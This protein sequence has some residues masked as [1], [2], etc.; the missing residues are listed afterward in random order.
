MHPVTAALWTAVMLAG[1]RLVAA[2]PDSTVDYSSKNLSSV[3]RD[4]PKGVEF[5]DLSCN[6]IQQL[7]RDDFRNMS[8]LRSLNVSWNSLETIDPDTFLD[9]PLLEDLDLSHN[10]LRNLSGQQYLLN[11]GNLQQLNL[12]SNAFS[13]MTLG[14]AFSSLV[15][16][17][18]LALEAKNISV[19]DFKN[20]AEVK[21]CTLTLCLGDELGYEARSLK[22]VNAQRLQMISSS[23][24]MDCG[25]Y[26]DALSLFA[27]VE[28]MNLTGGY[29]ELSKILSEKVKILTSHLYFT[30]ISIEWKDLTHYVNVILGSSIAHLGISG[31]VMSHL[32]YIDSYVIQES[33]MKSFSARQAMVKSFFFSQEAVCNFFINMPVESL[34][35]TTTSIIHMTCPKSPSPVLKLDF[36]NCALSD[37][38]F[39]RVK[40]QQTLECQN[41]GNVTQLILAGNNLKSLQLISVRTRYMKSLKYLQLGL[42]SLFYEGQEEC[43]WPPNIITMNLSSN[44]LTDSVLQ[45]LPKG[46]ETLD[47][48]NNQVSVVRASILKLENLRSLNLNDN[49]L[50]DLPVCDGFPILNELLLKSNSLHAPSVNN[51]KSCPKLRTL[52]VSHNPFTCTCPLRSFIHLGIKS[53]QSSHTSIGLWNWPIDYYCTYPE[54]L[55]D[56]IL[57]DTWIPEVT[58]NAGLLA[59]TILCPTVAL[60]VSVVVLCRRLD[61]L[62]YIRMIWQWTRAKHR[63]RTQSDDLAGVEFHA[64]VSYSQHDADWVQNALLPNLQGPAGRLRICQHQ[65]HFVPGKTIIENI[66]N[67]VEKSRRSIFVLSARFVKSDWCHY[68]LYF[69]NHQRLSRGSDGIVLVLL[70]PVPKYIIPSKYYQLKSM[71]D[72][73]TYLEW[74]QERSKQRLFWANLR[75][76][77]EADLPN[78]PIT[79]LEE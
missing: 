68:E 13:T 48:Q 55:R 62:W 35:I 45:C 41:L 40:G 54:N 42:N 18:R 56:T 34:A 33:K 25:P 28:L 21:L 73:H 61:G 38:I 32:P 39:S 43:V 15:K 8:L 20:I 2:S 60:I 3:P 52:D 17:K 46:I 50:R 71:M 58:C 51:L 64:F 10:R 44:C 75:A 5:L 1:L 9:A 31:V 29:R 23:E 49:R 22:G 57:K 53:D 4:L 11:T 24:L 63:A 76:A 36:S 6:H 77:L 19:G 16:L 26:A 7:H 69:A 59:A 79:D 70:E 72:R 30:D 12:T 67:C 14:S 47:L 27:E 66:M 74:P 65:K 78:A 37:S